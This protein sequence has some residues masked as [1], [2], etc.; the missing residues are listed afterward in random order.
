MN[1]EEK[2]LSI[3]VLPRAGCIKGSKLDECGF[4]LVTS[5]TRY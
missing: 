3:M 5:S 1:L 2:I 4:L